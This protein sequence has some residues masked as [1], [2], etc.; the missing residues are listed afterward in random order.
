MHL[1]RAVPKRRQTVEIE[2]TILGISA[3]HLK[4]LKWRC[5]TFA[6]TA[7]GTCPRLQ[8]AAPRSTLALQFCQQVLGVDRLG[9]D[10]KLVTLRSRLIQ[11][12]GG[13]GLARKEQ[14]LA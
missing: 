7:D 9:K 3:D 4:M 14:N 10:L 2:S 13:R 8:L 11:Q 6:A 5:P 1:E 12:I